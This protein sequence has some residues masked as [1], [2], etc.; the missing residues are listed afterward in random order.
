M[1]FEPNVW[2]R[3]NQLAQFAAPANNDHLTD[4]ESIGNIA[5]TGDRGDGTCL[6]RA[7]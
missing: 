5:A 4:V 3:L 7:N 6:R 1:T 2:I